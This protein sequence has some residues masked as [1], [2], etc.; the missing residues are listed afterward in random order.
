MATEKVEVIGGSAN[1]WLYSEANGYDL[2][3]PPT[4]ES[5]PIR[6]RL[7]L[8]TTTGC[9]TIDPAKTALVVVDLQNYFFSPLLGR[10]ADSI[11]LKVVDA[12]LEHGI[13]ACRKAGMPSCGWAGA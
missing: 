6:P 1:F 12:L 4:P 8:E 10:P 9:A 11:G 3:H 7:S 2:T 13:P 5:P